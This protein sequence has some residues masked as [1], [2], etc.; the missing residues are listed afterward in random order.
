[1]RSSW[2]APATALLMGCL[3]G[4]YSVG[5]PWATLAGVVASAVA[6]ALPV[7]LSVAVDPAIA[8]RS[9]KVA[10]VGT[11]SLLLGGLLVAGAAFP[12]VWQGYGSDAAAIS[13]LAAVLLT[14]FAA[15][16][17]VG[18]VST[19][20]QPGRGWEGQAIACGVLAWA[21]VGLQA[22]ALPYLFPIARGFFAVL[23]LHQPVP[24]SSGGFTYGW[25]AVIPFVLALILLYGIGFGL[26]AVVGRLGGT[27]RAR[28]SRP[29]RR[30]DHA[31]PSEWGLTV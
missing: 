3:V 25:V 31:A 13:V 18:T 2:L 21:G 12:A 14:P 17:A 20:A 5:P 10:A 6:L 22:V 1:M 8:R 24:T 26:A 27:L 30:P 7:T 29:R 4:G 9:W 15:G 16:F 28:L 11:I 23:V 19:R